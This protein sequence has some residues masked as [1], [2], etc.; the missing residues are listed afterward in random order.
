[1]SADWSSTATPSTTL[2]SNRHHVALP[3]QQ[4]VARHDQIERDLVQPAVPVPHGGARHPR[5]QGGHLAPGRPLGIALQVL[6][7][8]IHQRHDGGGEGL[9]DQQRPG[10]RQRG[11]DVEA[12]VAAAQAGDDLRQE[13]Q[14]HR[15]G[16]G[17]PDRRR[18][19]AK[20]GELDGEAGRE[21]ERH[22]RGEEA[23]GILERAGDRH[24]RTIAASTGAGY[25][26]DQASTALLWT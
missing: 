14:Q 21:A 10:H 15:H 18:P 6:P 11:D 8:G 25:D 24:S 20:P 19:G 2:P 7:A 12:E 13:R 4:P 17:R 22:Q 3:H 9:A 26:R 5:Q 1:V 23:A 16:D